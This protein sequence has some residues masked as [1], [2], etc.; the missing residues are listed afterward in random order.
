MKKVIGLLSVVSVCVLGALGLSACGGKVPEELMNSAPGDVAAETLAYSDGSLSWAAADGATEYAV[1]FNGGAEITTS[2]TRVAHAFTESFSAAVTPEKGDIRGNTTTKNFEKLGDV[3]PML[4]SDGS[5]YWDSVPNADAYIVKVDG[6]AGEPVRDTVYS[7]FSAGTHRVQVMPMNSADNG[8]FGMYGASVNVTYVAQPTNIKYDGNS[9]TWV[10]SAV[11]SGYEVY[12]DGELHETVNSTK[13]EYDAK[14]RSFNVAVRALG[15][16]KTTF[17]MPVTDAKPFVYLAPVTDIDVADGALVWE[18]V[19]EAD[20]YFIRIDNGNP[21]AVTEAVYKNLPIGASVNVEIKPYSEK[22]TYFSS[23]S[24]V[25]SVYILPAPKAHWDSTIAL[26]GNNGTNFYWDSVD[27][28]DGYTVVLQTPSGGEDRFE[29]GSSANHFEYAYT[30]A[31]KYTVSVIATADPATERYSSGMSERFMV[32]RLAAPVALKNN[33]ITSA[34]DNVA[35]GFTVSFERASGGSGYRI[36]KDGALLGTRPANSAQISVGDIVTS[37]VTEEQTFNYGIQTVGSQTPVPSGSGVYKLTLDSLS[38]SMLTFDIRVLAVPVNLE[39]SGSVLS[40]NGVDKANGYSLSGFGGGADVM[41]TSRDM[42]DLN[43]GSYNIAVCARGN[44][45]DILPS[46]YTPALN[47]VRLNAPSNIGISTTD[48]GEGQLV[49]DKVEFAKS[50]TVK[51]DHTPEPIAADTLDN[52]SDKITA[53]GTSVNMYAVADYYSE[54]KAVYYMSSQISGT[55]RFLRFN[56]I[57]FPSPAFNGNTLVWNKPDNINESV[58]TPTY[59]VYD[60]NRLEYNGDKNGTSMDLSAL[61]AGDYTFYVKTIGDGRTYINSDLSKAVTVTKLETPVVTR[62]E[63]DYVWTGVV[64]ASSY[65]VYVNGKLVK[66][67]V[68]SSVQSADYLY[69]PEFKNVGTYNVSVLAVGDGGYKT[70]N[71]SPYSIEQIA[72]QPDTP[73]FDVS[74]S[75]PYYSADGTIDVT[76]TKPSPNTTGYIYSVAGITSEKTGINF[77]HNPNTTGSF[78]VSVYAV[79]GKFDA[80]GI[81]YVDS[82][83][84]AKREMTLLAAPTSN[85]VSISRDGKLIWGVSD[86]AVEYEAEIYWDGSDAP[87]ETVT[88][89]QNTTVLD[90]SGHNSVVIKIRALGNGSNIVSSVWTT[91]EN[92]K[93]N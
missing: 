64:G 48:A 41:S 32:T 27:G 72:K 82:R 58:Y 56:E 59:R 35:K 39:M 91:Y 90:L 54:N 9:I 8:F 60:A 30:A 52:V 49:Y 19:P 63:T 45:A 31:G 68:H 46:N 89:T 76:V 34:A 20:G 88:V 84:A 16:G 47:V 26:D 57:T 4:D 69:T 5:V 67:V 43:A 7:D 78:E 6:K 75:A 37:E 13:L 2:Q 92:A 3:T 29:F 28:A 33:F 21:V 66:T 51:F 71:S 14:N 44:G 65:A 12:I 53:K 79:G 93:L 73:E 10:G 86:K 81:Y 80:D 70:I 22:D 11:A 87:S 24:E 61:P 55:V 42:S 15:D 1:S 77:S 25:K 50:Y 83:S 38:S 23:W 17:A 85:S 40:W 36:Y 62:T 74:Y 18:K